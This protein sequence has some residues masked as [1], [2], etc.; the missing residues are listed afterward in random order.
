ME[1]S[2]KVYS[3]I[4]NEFSVRILYKQHPELKNSNI[5]SGVLV[6]ID[7][8][9]CYLMTAKHNFK[10]EEDDNYWNV[11]IEELKKNIQKIHISNDNIGQVCTV[12]KLL[13]DNDK[14]DLLVFSITD[15]SE[16]IINLPLIK[17]DR[18]LNLKDMDC[19]FYGYP[20]STGTP[21]GML[22]YEGHLNPKDD[23]HIFRLDRTKS[24]KSDALNGFSGSGIF[25]EKENYYY[26]VGIF[27]AFEDNHSFYFG[28]DLNFVLDEMLYLNHKNSF[29][30]IDGD[31]KQSHII[32]RDGYIEPRTVY[33][34]ELNIHVAVCP[35][36]FE[37]YD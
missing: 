36:T 16:T 2:D 28:I 35:V 32:Y 21:S 33:I 27:T 10:L 6:K 20:D 14:Y 17:I 12:D 30:D 25:I 23:E 8:S 13:Y 7:E 3:N 24:V 5:G 18:S 15:W 29:V 1:N 22:S 11:D 26:L 9:N 37:E 31:I 34:E 19:C 4:I